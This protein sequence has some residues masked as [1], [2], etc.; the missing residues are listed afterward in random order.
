MDCINCQEHK[1][2]QI[3][4]GIGICRD[5][6]CI[7]I[8]NTLQPTICACCGNT[9]QSHITHEF[10]QSAQ[11]RNTLYLKTFFLAFK[12]YISRNG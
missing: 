9:L 12:T 8:H 1:S 11:T 2:L 4:D 3:I 5:P 10:C 7:F 6:Q